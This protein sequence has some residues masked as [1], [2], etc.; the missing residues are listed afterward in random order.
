MTLDDSQIRSI[1]T[2][3]WSEWKID[4]LYEKIPV[5]VL[6]LRTQIWRQQKHLRKMSSAK[7]IYFAVI[8]GHFDLALKWSTLIA[9]FNDIEDMVN[10][11]SPWYSCGSTTECIFCCYSPI[12]LNVQV[13]IYRPR[14]MGFFCL[15]PFCIYNDHHASSHLWS[16]QWCS[17]WPDL[18][19]LERYNVSISSDCA[20]LVLL[21]LRSYSIASWLLWGAFCA[22]SLRFPS[23][24]ISNHCSPW[25]G[26]YWWGIHGSLR[27]M[28]TCLRLARSSSDGYS[29]TYEIKCKN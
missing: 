21:F 18:P 19:R 12:I 11:G 7:P 13:W 23:S 29:A 6:F 9:S 3:I 20:H 5:Y 17:C 25:V 8:I 16:C 2:Q 15:W 10:I 22:C 26:P 28:V 4:W 24:C 14:Y 1:F 27:V